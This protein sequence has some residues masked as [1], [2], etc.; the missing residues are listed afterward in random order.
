GPPHQLYR[1]TT[2]VNFCD[3]LLTTSGKMT[4]FMTLKKLQDLVVGTI[5]AR[6]YVKYCGL[7][8]I[9]RLLL[10]LAGVKR[11]EGKRTL[12]YLFLQDPV[13]SCYPARFS[14]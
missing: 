12:K 9:D 14:D 2:N 11:S 8:Q 4:A 7:N 5:F 13:D 6:K 10:I 3:H 1:Y